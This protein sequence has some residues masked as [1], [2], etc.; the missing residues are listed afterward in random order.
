MYWNITDEEISTRA[1]SRGKVGYHLRGCRRCGGPYLN[2]WINQDDWPNLAYE[3]ADIELDAISSFQS[4]MNDS[5]RLEIYL[6]SEGGENQYYV[7]RRRKAR[8]NGRFTA[9][10]G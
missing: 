2:L 3:E 8:Y 4:P 10:L 1:P 5:I 6:A 9:Y 7:I